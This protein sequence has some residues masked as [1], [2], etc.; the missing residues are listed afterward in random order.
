LKELLLKLQLWPPDAEPTH[1][2]RSRCWERLKA[3]WERNAED[4]M[5]R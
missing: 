4:E 3:K 1:W 5:V 2:K